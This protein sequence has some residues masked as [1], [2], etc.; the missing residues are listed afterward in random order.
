ME[1]GKNLLEV[2]VDS[3][4]S[5]AAAQKGGADRL[6]LCGHLVIGGV[7]P[8]KELFL[9]VRRACQIPV[10]VLIRPRFGDFCYTEPEFERMMD[11][12]VRFRDLGADAVVCGCLLPDGNLDLERMKRLLDQAGNMEMTLHRAFDVCKDAEK[13]MEEAISLGIGTILTSGQADSALHGAGCLRNLNERS[14]GRIALMAGAGVK[15]SN[16]RKLYEKTGLHVYH[17]SA[18]RTEESQMKFRR[19]GIPMGLPGI[20]EYEIWRTDEE[21]VREAA[22]ILRDLS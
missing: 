11:Q 2:C 18:K 19:A 20:S 13:T 10:R 4:E 21:Q 3:L 17:M 7:T 14:Q 12:V 6:E 1:H 5:A 8:E 16:I 9:Q 15:S 22:E